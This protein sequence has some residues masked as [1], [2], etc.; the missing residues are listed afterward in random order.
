MGRVSKSI[1]LPQEVWDLLEQKAAASPFI[2]KGRY[3][4]HLIS[5]DPRTQIE[6]LQHQLAE[7]KREKAQLLEILQRLTL[8]TAAYVSTTFEEP[9][10]EKKALDE[11]EIAIGE[12][13]L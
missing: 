10:K 11:V 13:L 1:T 4:E 8:G 9:Q 5:S 3:I 6:D 2:R 12:M 7:Q